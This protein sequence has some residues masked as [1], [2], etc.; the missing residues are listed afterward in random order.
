M[1]CGKCTS[2]CPVAIH[3]PEFAPR[4]IVVKALEGIDVTK[5]RD[6]WLCTT[7]GRCVSVCPYE[8]DYVEFI[9]DLRNES[10]VGGYTPACSQGGLMQTA[11][12]MMANSDLEQHRLDW[13]VP[14]SYSDKG[15]IY[16]F[17]GCLPHLDIIFEE[18]DSLATAKSALEILNTAGITPAM[19]ERE[20]CCGHDLNWTGDEENFE[21][22][23]KKN[24]EAIRATGAKTIVFTCA[25]CLRTFDIDYQSIE[26]DLE[27]ELLHMSEFMER[28]VEEG[29]LKFNPL[30]EKVT[31]HD[32]CRLGRH[33]EIYDAPRDVIRECGELVEMENSREKATCCGVNA[34]ATCDAVS[35]QIQIGRVEEAKATGASRMLTTCPKCLI[36][37]NCA[38]A[39]ELPVEREKVD[40]PIEDLTVF[41]VKALKSAEGSGG[42]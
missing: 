19:S 40:I 10:V 33:M 8:V 15:E 37:F 3:N 17:Q 18:T 13:A 34:F 25:E 9:R 2:V 14:G 38:V 31:Y 7:C 6:I 4:L 12:R 36:H 20:V 35:K 41:A 16:Y 23:M 27:F 29:K 11:A 5:E 42:S 1:E 22:L 32:P 28:L 21:K 30:E 26:G 24:L 39:K